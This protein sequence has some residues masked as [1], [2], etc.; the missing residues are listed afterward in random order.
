ME[1]R[2]WFVSYFS[3]TASAPEGGLSNQVIDE[4]PVTWIAEFVKHDPLATLLFYREIRKETY[5]AVKS[6][7][8]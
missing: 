4:H 5:D 1:K 7:L 6:Q 8:G 2:Y 3:M